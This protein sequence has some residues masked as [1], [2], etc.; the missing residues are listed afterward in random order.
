MQNSSEKTKIKIKLLTIPNL[1]SLFRICL[2]PFIIW[3]YC[4]E[5]NYALAG[6]ILILSGLTDIVDG[7]IAR[8]FNMVSDVGKALDPVADKLTQASTLICLMMRFPLMILPFV[9]LVAKELTTSVLVL[10]V[11]KKT[12][13]VPMANWH[14]KVATILLY[15]MMI[16]HVFWIDINVIASQVSILICAIMV[17]VSFLLYV[18][19]HLKLIKR[20]KV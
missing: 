1:M 5:E 7:F 11:I 6:T 4:V 10:F 9:I 17:A 15:A 8:R 14:G 20:E 2:I 3:F 12:K 16:L 18:M 19:S 13:I